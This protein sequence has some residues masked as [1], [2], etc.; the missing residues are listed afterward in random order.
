MAHARE[1]EAVYEAKVRASAGPL[2]VWARPNGLDYCRL[3]LAVARRGG[4]AVA[5]NQI[6]RRL[7]ESFRLLQHEL[8][9]GYDLVVTARAH[10]PQGRAEY[11]TLLVTAV[12]ALE[13]KLRKTESGKQKAEKG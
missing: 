11:E 12:R 13:R 10:P 5:R 6:K 8:P 4:T 1:F 9:A 2:T 3:G 7:R